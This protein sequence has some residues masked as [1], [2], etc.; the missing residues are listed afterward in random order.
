MGVI[1]RALV[2]T[3]RKDDHWSF[4]PVLISPAISERLCH[5]TEYQL[6]CKRILIIYDLHLAHLVVGNSI[7]IRIYEHC[8]W[9]ERRRG[10][11]TS[12]PQY[13]P[14]LRMYYHRV[15]V[16]VSM[17][18]WDLLQPILPPL[19]CALSYCAAVHVCGSYRLWKWM[20]DKEP[21]LTNFGSIWLW[22]YSS[23]WLLICEGGWC[24]LIQVASD[25]VK[26]TDWMPKWNLMENIYFGADLMINSG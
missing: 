25:G 18:L 23:A 26:K 20:T 5:Q 16:V 9:D 22:D 6:R 2:F 7:V 19:W 1:W 12:H 15:F 14:T 21:Q 3:K 11:Y 17:I 8:C 13:I 24:I 10:E 4:G